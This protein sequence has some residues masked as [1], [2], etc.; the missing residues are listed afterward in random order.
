MK[1]DDHD[2]IYK[3]WIKAQRQNLSIPPCFPSWFI[4]PSREADTQMGERKGYCKNCGAEIEA[5]SNYCSRCGAAGYTT[6]QVPSP[7]SE[8]LNNSSSLSATA[9][10]SP[11]ARPTIGPT[12]SPTPTPK[13]LS[14]AGLTATS[15]PAPSGKQIVVAQGQQFSIELHSNPTTGYHWRPTFDAG[16]L[17]LKSQTF[18]SDFPITQQASHIGAGGTDVFRFEALR[19]GTTT[20]TFDYVRSFERGALDETSYTVIVR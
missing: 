1:S 2:L 15:A 5:D 19:A 16:A 20:I 12:G 6:K 18:A 9:V 14:T 17:A 4:F 8:P 11:S 10:A 13:V 7:I 3:R